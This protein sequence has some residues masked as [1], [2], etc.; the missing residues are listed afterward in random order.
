MVAE[1]A[2]AQCQL[3]AA[4]AGHLRTVVAVAMRLPTEAEAG[5]T[6]PVEEA[7]M[8]RH[9]AVAVVTAAEAAATTV[10]AITVTKDLI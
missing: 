1:M 9:Q 3:T 8:P 7:V 6:F 2:D 10:A 4:E 5:A